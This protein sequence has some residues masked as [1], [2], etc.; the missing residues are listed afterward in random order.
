MP[1]L[2]SSSLARASHPCA[3]L[4]AAL[5]WASEQ[6]P[7]RGSDLPF[8]GGFIASFSYELGHLFEPAAGRREPHPDWPLAILAWCP[9][10]L[11]HDAHT[12]G[13]SVVGSPD[14]SDLDRSAAGTSATP[15]FELGM[16]RPARGAAAGYQARVADILTRIRDGEVYQVNLSHRL[17]AP[18]AGSARALLHN[19]ARRARPPFA[20][21]LDAPPPARTRSEDRVEAERRVL[22]SAS[23]EMLVTLGART[24]QVV[25]R[26]I[27]GTRPASADP[28][29]LL[30]A[31]KDR[32]ELDM[33]V[34]LMRNDLG[35]VCEVGSVRVEDRRAIERH[36][37]V[38]QAVATIAGTLRAD[39]DAMDLLAAAFPAG[40][41]TG[42]PK[43]QAMRTIA[44]LESAPRGPY[45]GSVGYLGVDGG[46]GL[47]VAIR[48]GLIV[49]E[50]DESRRDGFARARLDY[51]VGAGIVA[52]SDPIA[53]W[54]ETLAKARAWRG[55]SAAR[56][57]R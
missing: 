40:S 37:G 13:W 44:S 18:F 30:H 23:P 57:L 11:I 42:A 6:H 47:S 16:L 17:R 36:G 43:V 19:L 45:C 31:P 12:D 56:G 8:V 25:T 3:D 4:R 5:A 54:R 20:A 50:A 52:D 55:A 7:P 15:A 33:I 39:A 21:Y 9:D 2:A 48:T 14:L 26:P 53:E 51:H 10:A 46:A 27:K 24:R 49:G 22:V 28:A 41:I 29:E 1:P 34:D 32:A 38:L 35:R